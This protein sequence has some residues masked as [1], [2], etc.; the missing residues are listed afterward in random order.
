MSDLAE[1]IATALYNHYVVCLSRQLSLLGR[2][3]I[4]NGQAHFGIFEEFKSLI[5]NYHK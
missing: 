5:E 3:E 2:R 4:H 1:K